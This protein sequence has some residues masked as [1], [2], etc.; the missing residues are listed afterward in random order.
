VVFS[1]FGFPRKFGVI[2]VD[3]YFLSNYHI[4]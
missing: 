3:L 2:G 1:R 4:L